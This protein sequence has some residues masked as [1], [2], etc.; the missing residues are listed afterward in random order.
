[1]K[2]DKIKFLFCLLFFVVLAAITFRCTWPADHVF[3]A[4]D[5]NIGRLGSMKNGIPGGLA[6]GFSAG[7][8]L[9]VSGVPSPR[10]FYLF[11]GA[12]PLE[13]F[14]NTFYGIVLVFGSASMI[15]FLRLW[16]RSWFASII[17]ALIGFWF[18]SILL[19]TG[20]HAYKMEVLAFSV[21]SLCFIEN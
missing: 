21:L 5:L 11:L 3:S 20:G 19:A 7:P 15:W 18:N 2:N 14:A 12:M 16:G 17:G 1:M 10:L 9:G 8:V 6:G 13:L 4:S